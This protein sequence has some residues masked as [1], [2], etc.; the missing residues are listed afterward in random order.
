MHAKFINLMGENVED[1]AITP[2]NPTSVQI[3]GTMRIYGSLSA[4]SI[5]STGT[6]KI[7]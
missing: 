3:N 2:I 1:P 4:D 7:P 6:A 5:V